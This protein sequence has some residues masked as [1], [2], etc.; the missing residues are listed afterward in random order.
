MLRQATT[1]Q[2]VEIF[3]QIVGA[4]FSGGL[5]LGYSV[6]DAVQ[7]L[8]R[9]VLAMAPRDFVQFEGSLDAAGITARLLSTK[10]AR[11]VPLGAAFTF[12]TMAGTVLGPGSFADPVELVHGAKDIAAGLDYYIATTQP[13]AAGELA[14]P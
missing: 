14:R 3:R 13:S 6:D 2:R 10:D 8:A 1:E 12:Q 5:V 9:T 11:F 4:G 7:M